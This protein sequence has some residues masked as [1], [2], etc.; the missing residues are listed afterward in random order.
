MVWY[1]IIVKGGMT[2]RGRIYIIL[3]APAIVESF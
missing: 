2:D 3:G 1:N